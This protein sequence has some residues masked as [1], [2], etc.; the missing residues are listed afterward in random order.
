MGM[1]S[2]FFLSVE[3][4][5]L[6]NVNGVCGPKKHDV[7]VNLRDLNASKNFK[8]LYMTKKFSNSIK[9]TQ[10]TNASPSRSQAMGESL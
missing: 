6:A 1:R 7:C 10:K 2:F 5:N 4:R 9:E 3:S 8:N